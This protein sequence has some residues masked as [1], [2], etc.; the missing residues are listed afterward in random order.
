MSVGKLMGT[1]IFAALAASICC[2][3]P[4]LALIAGT[5]SIT[6]S[7]AWLTPA[8]PYMIGLTVVVLGFAW[9]QKLKPPVDDCGCTVN[10][11]SS[12]LRSKSFLLI[13]TIVSALMIAFPA[14]SKIF[15]PQNVKE[16]VV[17][18]PSKTQTVEFGI[19]GMTCAGC[20]EHVK[21]EI[22][23]LPGIAQLTVSYEKRN[24]IV[25]F[26]PSKTTVNALHDAINKTGYKVIDQS[27]KK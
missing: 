27:L 12:F 10:E 7:F 8:R 23:E 6:A 4:V 25:V 2:I 1:G 15:F 19:K 21:A 17:I 16:Q 11:K 18:E 13:I 24:A 3:T 20:E 9:Y 26:D 22:N 5:S 14:Y